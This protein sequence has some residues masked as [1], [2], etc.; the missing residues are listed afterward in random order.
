MW[1]HVRARGT[2]PCGSSTSRAAPTWGCCS[3]TATSC[4]E[5]YNMP[6]TLKAQH[7]AFLTAGRALYSDMGRI[8]CSVS[9]DTCGWHDTGQRPPRRRRLARRSTAQARYQ[10]QRNE[11]H[12]NAHD[13]FLVELGKWGLGQQDLVPNLNLFSK[14]VADAEGKLQLVSGHSSAGQLRRPAGGDERAGGAE[15]LPAPA[16]SR[17]ELRA[18]AGEA[19]ALAVGPAGPRRPDCRNSRPEN[20]ARASRT[21]SATS[22]R[23]GDDHGVPSDFKESRLRSRA[24]RGR[25]GGAR[26]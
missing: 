22:C 25:R 14:V 3:T 11:F 7:T 24:R 1:S 19:G 21:P 6:D 18:Q 8:L 23:A 20:A 16:R 10:E 15:H 13:C 9:A 12:R 4:C 17:R 5:R 26:G 2:T